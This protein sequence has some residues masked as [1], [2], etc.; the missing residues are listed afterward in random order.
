MASENTLPWIMKHRKLVRGSVL[1]V[2]ARQYADHTHLN[3]R[4]VFHD[5]VQKYI[6]CDLSDGDN[7]D[8]LLDITSDFRA[9]DE[10]LNGQRFDAIF[11]ISV[12]EHIPDVFTAARNIG[13]LLRKSG[14]LLLSV[15]FVFR[16][17]G[18]PA[19]YWRFTPDGVKHLF[20]SLIFDSEATHSMM[21]TQI[22]GDL[23]RI[24]HPYSRMN[25][26]IYRPKERAERE[27]LKLQ[28]LE[29]PQ[30]AMGEYSLAPVMLNMIG[31][32]TPKRIADKVAE[33]RGDATVATDELDNDEAVDLNEN[34]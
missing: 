31:L 3:L 30:E 22:P 21:A 28:K 24:P 10:A 18:Y 20:P 16:Y 29:S 7:V 15:P 4:E 32:R 27:R 17:H 14:A 25:R 33:G 5:R 2:G 9:I 13:R 12:L 19:D 34:R 26:F 1:E 11:C 8:M 23:K 6:G